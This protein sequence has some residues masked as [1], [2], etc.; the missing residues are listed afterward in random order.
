[1]RDNPGD[2]LD[3]ARGVCRRC[4]KNSLSSLSSGRSLGPAWLQ[5]PIPHQ[6][7]NQ[8]KISFKHYLVK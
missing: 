6:G 4:K 5:E 3:P 8:P 2:E 1:M 7:S